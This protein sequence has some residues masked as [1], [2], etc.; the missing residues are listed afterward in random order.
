ML[1]KSEESHTRVT[2]K[3]HEALLDLSYI[4][5]IGETMVATAVI[6]LIMKHNQAAVS[7][8]KGLLA[9]LALL[10]KMVNSFFVDPTAKSEQPLSVDTI[11]FA[12]VPPCAHPKD[13]VRNAATKI[14]LDVQKAT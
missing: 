2:N 8:P 3:I 7:N 12:A 6:D 9:Q 13:D 5:Q 11:V 4:E 10:Y 14:L 1:L